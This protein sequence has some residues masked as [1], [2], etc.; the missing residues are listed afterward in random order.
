MHKRVPLLPPCHLLLRHAADGYKQECGAERVLRRGTS[1]V[2]GICFCLVPS[3]CVETSSTAHLRTLLFHYALQTHLTHFCCWVPVLASRDEP[4]QAYGRGLHL[5]WFRPIFPRALV[6]PLRLRS[7]RTIEGKHPFL[8]LY[9]YSLLIDSFLLWYGLNGNGNAVPVAW[10][11]VMPA[12]PTSGVQRLSGHPARGEHHQAHP[13]PPHR[14]DLG[15]P[16]LLAR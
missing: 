9:F 8:K 4:R 6:R 1:F 12:V 13:T 16:P 11:P 3:L 2:C 5:K 7:H 14:L 15:L 10:P